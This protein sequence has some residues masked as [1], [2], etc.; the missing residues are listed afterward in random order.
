M[1]RTTCSMTCLCVT[2]RKFP[3]KVEMVVVA[4]VIDPFN[5]GILYV[6]ARDTSF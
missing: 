1:A 5:A 4:S 3:R 2:S 6:R